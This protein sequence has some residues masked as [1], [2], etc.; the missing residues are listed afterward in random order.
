MILFILSSFL[1]C[2]SLFNVL[3]LD[4]RPLW[5]TSI[6]TTELGYVFSF[7]CLVV[8][9]LTYKKSRIIKRHHFLLIAAY[10]LFLLPLISNLK[11]IQAWQNKFIEQLKTENVSLFSIRNVLL[12]FPKNTSS[13]K[14][15][16]YSQTHNLSLELYQAQCEGTCPFVVVVHGGGWDSGDAKQLEHLHQILSAHGIS[17]ASINYRLVP[18]AIW[19]AQKQDLIAAVEYLKSNAIDLNL[20]SSRYLVMG[21]S[22]G[23]QIAGVFAYTYNDPALK[24]YINIY[25]PTDLEFG[26]EIA[27]DTDVIESKKLLENYMGGPLLANVNQYRDASLLNFVGASSVPTLILHG[28]NDPLCWYKHGERLTRRLRYHNVPVVDL[29]F[30]YATHGLD[31]F[32]RGSNGQISM[33]AILEFSKALL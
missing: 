27:N 26:Y 14:T 4:Y 12:G 24:G 28:R 7:L 15:I 9:V 1:F 19:P 21:R 33:S 11:H 30:P 31:Y 5:M 8:L 25:G 29:F 17:V 2:L 3:W 32:T 6:V 23:S 20:D 22:A 16:I 18:K 10:V 13:P